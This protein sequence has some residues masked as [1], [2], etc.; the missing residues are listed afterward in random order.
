RT[1]IFR[2]NSAVRP[3]NLA[4]RFTR[5]QLSLAAIAVFPLLL[6]GLG[7]LHLLQPDPLLTL[8][9]LGV[10]VS[11]RWAAGQPTIDPNIGFTSQALGHLAARDL[12]HGQMP[13]W[14][15][16]EGLG[17]P[18]AGEM[19]AAALFPPVLL[20]AFPGGIL[21]FHI[22]LEIL[23]GL[24]MFLLMESLGVLGLGSVL[25]ALLFEANGTFAWLANAV[26]NPIPFL[27]WL[28]LGIERAARAAKN[29]LRN[30]WRLIAVA[31]ALSLYA[32]FPEVAY[33][34]G[35]LALGWA[36]LR[37]C[38]GP[39]RAAFVRKVTLGGATGLL[40]AAPILAAFA[41]Y[42]P[43]AYVAAHTGAFRNVV[44]PPAGIAQWILPYV[45]GPIFAFNHPTVGFLWGDV[46][47]YAGVGA[48]ILAITG[49]FLAS[50][51]VLAVLLAAWV[52]LTFAAAYGAPGIHD[53]IVSLPGVGL[54]AYYRYF[55]PS[56][57]FALCVLA[58]FAIAPSKGQKAA[59]SIGAAVTFAL[60]CFGLWQ[61]RA[62]VHEQLHSFFAGWVVASLLIGG[63]AGFAAVRGLWR[64]NPR[65][66]AAA[67]LIE[68]FV[69]FFV[70]TL[71]NP[72]RGHLEIG[73]I[74]YL[75][76]HLGFQRYFSLG[77]LAPNYGSYYGLASLN[78][79]DLPVPAA[80]V[81]FVQQRLD[82]ETNGITFIG[83]MV[84][85][86]QPSQQEEFLTRLPAYES[87]GV[88]YLLAP[89]SS[90]LAFVGQQP[91]IV[92][93]DQTMDIY[94]LP[95]PAPY[96]SAPGCTIAPSTRTEL[97]ADCAAPSLLTRLEVDMN[98][99]TA[100]SNGKAKAIVP[101][102]GV[103][104]GVSLPAGRSRVSFDY[105]PPHLPLAMGLF[106]AGWLIL[107]TGLAGRR[108]A[109]RGLP[110]GDPV[111]TTFSLAAAPLGPAA[112]PGIER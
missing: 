54:S 6:N 81:K 53:A 50:D 70:P 102:Q 43:Q 34:D 107:L 108:Q 26:V 105:R 21:A 66:V 30:G 42:L 58:G 55:P 88:K 80:T 65:R 109:G 40:L 31:L 19:Q 2:V 72:R 29:R 56:W 89:A 100:E 36:I 48:L 33:L 67:V 20:L 52:A 83:T 87:A 79:N 46:G 85:P 1:S 49:A 64:A 9:G 14:N 112:G 78:F 27:P 32:G 95:H 63:M 74:R 90:R 77:P 8:S 41:G 57:S 28:I 44:L 101:V 92:Y 47:G 93:R 82:P 60:A 4:K 35:L 23:A 111:D 91:P 25:A 73:G 15:P 37:L 5:R 38:Q 110:A 18:L 96:L 97:V 84:R 76:Q 106:A 10:G 51:R 13:W 86:G 69:Y 3:M 24:G 11:G 103:F 45:F 17:A 16:Y 104:Q 99:W 62:I 39:A 98:G 75:Q 68:A 7:L 22:L 94:Q 12:F 61:A 71:A 59:A